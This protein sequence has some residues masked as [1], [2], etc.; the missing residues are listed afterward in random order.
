[1]GRIDATALGNVVIALGGGRVRA[2]DAIDH[3]VGL[4]DLRRLTDPTDGQLGLVHAATE[5]DADAAIAAVQAAYMI[6]SD[7]PPA[8]PLL[9][10]HIAQSPTD[11]QNTRQQTKN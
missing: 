7:A 1:M 10:G 6:A 4:S 9:R 2:G 3:R 8:G 11:A 5:S